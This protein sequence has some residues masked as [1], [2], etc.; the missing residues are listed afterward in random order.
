MRSAQV[1]RSNAQRPRSGKR[2]VRFV[3]RFV[4]VPLMLGFGTYTVGTD[5]LQGL[6]A[7]LPILV[8]HAVGF[9]V[10]YPLWTLYRRRRDAGGA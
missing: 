2:V 1:L 6:V 8:V 4:I 10:I 7:L 5:G 9:L 3:M